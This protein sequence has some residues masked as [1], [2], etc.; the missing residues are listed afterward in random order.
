MH[1][2]VCKNIYVHIFG[3]NHGWGY[4]YVELKLSWV[5]SNYQERIRPLYALHLLSVIN[6]VMLPTP[7]WRKLII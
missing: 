4:G 2:N 1:T 5:N 7:F 6:F 3:S